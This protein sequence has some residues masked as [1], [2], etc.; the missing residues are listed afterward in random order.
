M[1][2]LAPLSFLT[3]RISVLNLFT[4]VLGT[5][6]AIAIRD[7]NGTTS[8]VAFVEADDDYKTLLI[9]FLQES[10][11]KADNEQ[12]SIRVNKQQPMAVNHDLIREHYLKDSLSHYLPQIWGSSDLPS[13]IGKIIKD[14]IDRVCRKLSPL[15]PSPLP[16][17]TNEMKVFIK[18]LSRLQLLAE[19]RIGGILNSTALSLP[20]FFTKRHHDIVLEALKRTTL[21]YI[22][23]L[24]TVYDGN[25]AF[26]GIAATGL[27]I[28][29][30]SRDPIGWCHDPKAKCAKVLVVEYS[31]AAFAVS[32]VKLE[33]PFY[34]F[35]APSITDLDLGASSH[36]RDSLGDEWYW[37]RVKSRIKD[38]PSRVMKFPTKIVLMGDSATGHAFLNALREALNELQHQRHSLEGTQAL[39]S[40]E[41]GQL[42]QP[43]MIDPL[44]AAARGAAMQAK[45]KMESPLGCLELSSCYEARG[46]K[47]P[48]KA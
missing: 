32:F 23:P 19:H 12:I 29:P 46:E 41:V 2:A 28:C 1:G 45:R 5:S 4:D 43:N 31:K 47:K 8:D 30:Q 37:N 6:R 18:M 38:L 16:E 15:K 22:P 34:V 42:M 40:S 24:W 17:P 10:Q 20:T 35:L 25:A 3:E 13:Y 21:D 48:G 14:I 33:G 9:K 27:G 36:S 11:S 39:S 44:Y 7:H 26:A